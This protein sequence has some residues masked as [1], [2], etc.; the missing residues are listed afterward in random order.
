[1]DY[2][3]PFDNLDNERLRLWDTVLKTCT[4]KKWIEIKGEKVLEI[5]INTLLIGLLCWLC[6]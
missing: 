6:T 4:Q 5:E 2:N 1:M 3:Q